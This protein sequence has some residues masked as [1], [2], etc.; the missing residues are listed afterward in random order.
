MSKFEDAIALLLADEGGDYVPDDQG[1]GPSR[2][3]VTLK[4]AQEFHPDWTVADIWNLTRFGADVFYEGAFWN[5]WHIGMIDDQALAYG[6]FYRVVNLGP[7]VIAWLQTIVGVK[8]DELI[9]P[10]TT[11][12]INSANPTDLLTALRKSTSDYYHQDVHDHPEKVGKLTG[13]LIR[14]AKC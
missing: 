7:K 2:W 4:S 3:G 13:W 6:V 10:A 11:A 1:R 14:N 8:P 9:G 12:A 5:R